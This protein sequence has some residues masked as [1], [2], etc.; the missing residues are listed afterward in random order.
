[1]A[2]KRRRRSA[3]DIRDLKV[4]LEL[5]HG[6]IHSPP[7]RRNS[8]S[9]SIDST[10]SAN[11]QR[12][13]LR[14]DKLALPDSVRKRVESMTRQKNNSFTYIQAKWRASSALCRRQGKDLKTKLRAHYEALPRLQSFGDP[15]SLW[16]AC[17]TLTTM[18]FAGFRDLLR[19]TFSIIRIEARFLWWLLYWPFAILLGSLVFSLFG[20][21]LLAW[22]YTYS[23]NTYL[24]IFCQGDFPVARNWICSNWDQRHSGHFQVQS[25]TSLNGPFENILHSRENS[26][27]YEL[28][29]HIARYETQIRSFRATLAESEYAPS[30]QKWFRE[31]FT[32]CIDQSKTAIR[33]AQVFHAH[34]VKTINI[35]I[36]DTA[37][38]VQKLD[39]S[40]YLSSSSMLEPTDGIL[41]QSVV[42]LNSHNL[43]HLPHGIEPFQERSARDDNVRGLQIM[44]E[45]VVKMASRVAVGRD[46]VLN[47]QGSLRDVRDISEGISEYVSECTR[48]NEH[49]AIERRQ[50]RFFRLNEMWYGQDLKGYQIAQRKKSVETMGPVFKDAMGFVNL[51]AD[52]LGTAY[53]SCQALLGDLSIQGR[54][55][56]SGQDVSDWMHKQV[57]ILTEGMKDLETQ[58]KDFKIE[59]MRFDDQ[60]FGRE[61]S[62]VVT[63]SI[64][65]FT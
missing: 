4:F 9:A 20:L 28:P 23:S 3:G 11:S 64:D 44:R 24:N 22:T 40:G 27:S 30:D 12:R 60:L 25:T 50:K 31:E 35:H 61:S 19:D 63:R 16:P 59:Q 7:K 55:A 47:L 14:W 57:H 15:G 65:S 33:A 45:H 41:K 51:V 56:K 58:L 53:D 49:E 36:S 54:A 32:K 39:E 29:Y 2:F 1:M 43:V 62:K 48:S 52:E 8:A 46:L 37:Y 34:M 21:Q 38:L 42:W 26:M 18:F 10:L 17:K 6:I 5:R 13:Y